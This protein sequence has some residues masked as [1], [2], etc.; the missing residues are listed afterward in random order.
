MPPTR[1]PASGLPDP[2]P[3]RLIASAP[4][5]NG[6]RE[7]LPLLVFGAATLA[8]SAYSLLTQ[9]GAGPGRIPLWAYF[10]GLGTIAL[11]GGVLSS[12][13]VEEIERA[14]HAGD[15][16]GPDLVVVSRRDWERR[17]S[18]DRPAASALRRGRDRPAAV[19][20]V[21]PRS[22]PAPGPG[23]LPPSPSRVFAPSGR[24]GGSPAL[25]A[26]RGERE[27][28][29]HPP[30]GGPEADRILTELNAIELG[31]EARSPKGVRPRSLARS[32]APDRATTCPHCEAPRRAGEAAVTCDSCGDPICGRCAQAPPGDVSGRFCSTCSSLLTAPTGN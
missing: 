13:S 20:V 28:A 32:H 5:A 3:V 18:T 10:A 4:G 14:P 21:A 22:G 17:P 8:L 9:H 16:L 15:V 19:P 7:S 31:L 24:P 23:V 27:P 29:G 2:A 11:I 26:R 1:E 30:A 6:L 25:G 12:F